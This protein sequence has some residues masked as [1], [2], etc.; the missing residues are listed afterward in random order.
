MN[1]YGY[2]EPRW[3]KNI[4]GKSKILREYYIFGLGKMNI[5][6]FFEMDFRMNIL[7]NSEILLEM[8]IFYITETDE[9][10]NIFRK[11]GSGIYSE[12]ENGELEIKK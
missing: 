7:L 9:G 1:I 4:L 10:M 6:Y 11:S 2:S 3:G 12:G 5:F 8:N